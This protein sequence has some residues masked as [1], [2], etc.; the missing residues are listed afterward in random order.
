[1][2]SLSES[3]YITLFPSEVS[4]KLWNMILTPVNLMIK[5]RSK[6]ST[7][8]LQ[9][10]FAII[11]PNGYKDEPKLHTARKYQHLLLAK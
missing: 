6:H 5:K 1:M 3:E 7:F 4:L 11:T 2:R 8:Y 9:I 10:K